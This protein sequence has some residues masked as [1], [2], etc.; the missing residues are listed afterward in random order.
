M[1][2]YLLRNKKEAYR[3]TSERILAQQINNSGYPVVKLY[4]NNECTLRLVHRLVAAAFV[5][6]AGETV[7]HQ[8][9]VKTNNAASNLEWASYTE[10]HLHAVEHGLNKQARPVTIA[11]VRYAS[12]SQAAKGERRAHR[13][14][15]RMLAEVPA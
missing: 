7:N 6:G 5:P 14:I 2:R 1:Q 3:R 9:G 12:I 11:G 8:D 15:R 10:N 13:T 4:L